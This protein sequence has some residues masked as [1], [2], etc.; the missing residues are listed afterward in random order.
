MS[1]DPKAFPPEKRTRALLN[2]FGWQGGT[3]H[4]I[5]RETGVEVQDLLY[6]DN[7]GNL[8]SNE[9]MSAARTCAKEYRAKF[10][11]TRRGDREFWIGVAHSILPF[12][13]G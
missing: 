8:R 11:V 12:E 1:Y 2:F 5:A 13:E 4:Q 7:P 10:A 3:I 9:G 6:A